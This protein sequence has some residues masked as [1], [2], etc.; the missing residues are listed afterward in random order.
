[1]N[2]KNKMD[3]KWKIIFMVS[4][5]IIITLIGYKILIAPVF[6]KNKALEKQIAIGNTD[7]KSQKNKSNAI[8]ILNKQL[9]ILKK[10]REN[11]QPVGSIGINSY[12]HQF[13][14]SITTIQQGGMKIESKHIASNIITVL[15]AELA[16]NFPALTWQKITMIQNPDRQDFSLQLE[17]VKIKRERL[18]ATDHPS[19]VSIQPLPKFIV[20]SQVFNNKMLA[21]K[22][23]GYIAKGQ[24]MSAIL[25]NSDNQQIIVHKGQFIADNHLKIVAVTRTATTVRSLQTQKTYQLSLSEAMSR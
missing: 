14:I 11:N 20:D 6:V 21:W 17:L 12:I 22:M 23:I 7:I 16:Q 15:L 8:E 25:Q 9:A 5:N 13:P 1:M 2:G 18:N 24:V 4:T 19:T 3:S 10:Y